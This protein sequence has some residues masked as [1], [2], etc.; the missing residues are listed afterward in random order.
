[1]S[2]IVL[3]IRITFIRKS[4]KQYI[5]VLYIVGQYVCVYFLVHLV[6]IVS[7]VHIYWKLTTLKIN[8][9]YLYISNNNLQY[10]ERT[11]FTAKYLYIFAYYI[12][13]ALNRLDLHLTITFPSKYDLWR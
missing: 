6:R 13:Y 8:Q 11:V 4:S 3:D 5:R 10:T 7:A 1:M 12:L 9:K 2:S